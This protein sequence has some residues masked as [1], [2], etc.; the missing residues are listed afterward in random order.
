VAAPPIKSGSLPQPSA[1]TKLE[2]K[3]PELKVTPGA[4][5]SKTWSPGAGKAARPSA[6]PLAGSPGSAAELINEAVRAGQYGPQAQ[7]SF[8]LL[9]QT[10]ALAGLSAQTQ[11]QVL[12][13]V[14][15]LIAD[16]ARKQPQDGSAMA[17]AIAELGRMIASSGFAP[18][19]PSQQA[20]L[21]DTFLRLNPF[22]RTN[23]RSLCSRTLPPTSKSALLDVDATGRTLIENLKALSLQTL[24]LPAE[25][26]NAGLDPNVY[27]YSVLGE[28]NDPNEINQ[29]NRATCTVT[30]VQYLLAKQN[31]AEY[32]RLMTGLLTVE[33]K[34]QLRDGSWLSRVADSVG[35]DDDPSRNGSER[36]LQS[37]LMNYAHAG[38]S[39]KTD[40]S[41][42]LFGLLKLVGLRDRQTLHVARAVLGRDFAVFTGHGDNRAASTREG[43][44]LEQFRKRSGKDI[45]TSVRFGS[46]PHM[47]VVQRIEGDRVLYRDPVGQLGQSGS[48]L[49]S[50][51]VAEFA[52]NFC[53]AILER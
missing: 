33:G 47:V 44:V 29:G 46:S 17:Y 8:N 24:V 10:P 25:L 41:P 12:R 20:S 21:L 48:E 37:A 11:A 5:A 15:D 1:A 36:L 43:R 45:L 9:L 51:T 16:E 52:R 32:A 39:N 28:L 30:S 4:E 6:Q 19:G 3:D 18:L 13:T 27:L 49:E 53:W 34:V 14:A 23:L 38:Y 31:P 50:M 2:K 26:K 7:A 35:P 40:S 42:E 22:G